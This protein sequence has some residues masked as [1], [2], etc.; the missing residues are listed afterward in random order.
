M[1]DA[2]AKI[3]I[4]KPA[5]SAFSVVKSTSVP[6]KTK[7][8]PN[9]NYSQVF[10]NNGGNA[11]LEVP[12]A[13]RGI[14]KHVAN[15]FSRPQIRVEAPIKEDEEEEHD[16][17]ALLAGDEARDIIRKNNKKDLMSMTMPMNKN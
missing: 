12:R 1:L 2:V 6:S 13:N 17:A 5:T 14:M 11:T 3:S 9:V 15:S 8:H 7:V 10:H 4:L 16:Q